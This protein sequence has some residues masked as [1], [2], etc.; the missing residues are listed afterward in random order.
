VKR[1]LAVARARHQDELVG[2]DGDEDRD[3]PL[4]RLAGL[5]ALEGELDAERVVLDA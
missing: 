3:H 4:T 1:P 2:G 5:V